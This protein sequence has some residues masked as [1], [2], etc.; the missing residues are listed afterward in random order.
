MP[1]IAVKKKYLT[2]MSFVSLLAIL[3]AMTGWISQQFP[4]IRPALQRLGV[5][6]LFALG[7][8]LTTNTS[9]A[10][11]GL[12]DDH[13]DGEI[14]ALYAGNGSLVP[15]RFTLEQALKRDRPILI[16]YYVDDSADCKQYT[17]VI[18]Q[19]QAF[20]GRVADF[21]PIRVDSIPLQAN[22]VPKEAGYYY[23]GLVPQTVLL[24][25]KGKVVL[26]Q[27]GILAFE[28][29]DDKFRK[30]FDL[31]PRSQSVGLKRRSLNEVNTELVQE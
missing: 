4:G 25:G 29:V 23:Q 3:S 21:L 2:A 26:N 18:S 17:T 12:T 24:D 27:T 14:F 13:Y 8:L 5:I 11:A 30:V 16:V 15:P 19:L 22:P 10:W 9:S 28:Q 1:L 31:L 7:L 6:L 20:Y